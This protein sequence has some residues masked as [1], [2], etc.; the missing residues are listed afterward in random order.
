MSSSP[1][2]SLSK[3]SLQDGEGD[4]Y[5]ISPGEERR[6]LAA[7]GDEMQTDSEQTD[8]VDETGRDA[9]LQQFD[10]LLRPAEQRIGPLNPTEE[11]IH[12]LRRRA[13][14]EECNAAV[15]HANQLH[16]EIRQRFEAERAARINLER[17][18]D[19]MVRAERERMEGEQAREE[20][21]M[22]EREQ[23]EQREVSERREREQA[24]GSQANR[25][26]NQLRGSRSGY[27]SS[28]RGN[29]DRSSTSSSRGSRGNWSG[30][31]GGARS[32]PGNRNLEGERQ[33]Q[34]GQSEGTFRYRN[35]N[36]SR[37]N[38]GARQNRSGNSSF[39]SR[40]TLPGRS[41]NQNQVANRV[42]SAVSGSGSRGGGLESRG[43][44]GSFDDL[45]R[46]LLQ[47]ADTLNLMAHGIAA[48]S[49]LSGMLFKKP[50]QPGKIMQGR[51]ERSGRKRDWICPRCRLS[52]F[53][54]RSTCPRCGGSRF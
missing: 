39:S 1:A 25:G 43:S 14:I 6:I 48:Q 32:L 5:V 24:G 11:Q 27:Q 28:S 38:S 23:R 54:R 8:T 4:Q 20:R 26:G 16:Q 2:K 29:R 21:A 49:R 44:R 52:V 47:C 40:E 51:V 17:E 45:M 9:L 7:E 22:R 3:M 42:E 30:T 19:D 46:P 41:N 37:T 31:R 10:P 18:R 12:E 53:G 35:I 13:V 36:T 33:V 34:P 50:S 15:T